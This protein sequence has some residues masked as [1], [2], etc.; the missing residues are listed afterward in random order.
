MKSLLSRTA[1]SRKSTQSSSNHSL[2]TEAHQQID[3]SPLGT[4]R[5]SFF[6]RQ[7]SLEDAGVFKL[8][9]AGSLIS[10]YSINHESMFLMLLAPEVGGHSLPEEEEEKQRL[11]H[12]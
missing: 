11:T 8:N 9:A 6:R 2:T 7:A 4:K 1:T 10:S 5:K 12:S 3:V